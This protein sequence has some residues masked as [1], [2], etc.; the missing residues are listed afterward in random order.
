[1]YVYTDWQDDRQAACIYDRQN[2]VTGRHVDI[3][4]DEQ[5]GKKTDR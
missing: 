3:W 4:A 2:S 5:T 1:M